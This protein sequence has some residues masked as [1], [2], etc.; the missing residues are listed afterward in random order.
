M[1]RLSRPFFGFTLV[2][3]LISPTIG[4]AAG[5]VPDWAADAV[6]YQ[7]FPERFR[8]GDPANNPTR[9]SLE[10]PINP[11]EKWRITP[12]TGDWYSRDEWETEQDRASDLE[13]TP[14][15]F[16]T[17]FDR[18]YG[19]D[20]QGV[21]EK[22]DY[23][24]DLGINTI[25]FNPVFYARSLHKYDGNSFHHIDPYFGPDPKGDLAVMD[26][27]T[28]DPKTWKW[29][30]ADKLFL[31]LMGKAHAKKIRV[32]IDGVF[33]HTGRDFFAF[34][35]L[36][37]TRQKSP[38]T[39]WYTVYSFDDPRTV[40]NEFDYKGWWGYKSLPVFAA[41]PDRND[42]HPGPKGYIFEA[43]RRWMDPDG[44]GDP[45][46]GIDGWRLDV[47]DE[48]PP[49][50]WADW[51]AHIRE[52]NPAIYT[53]AEV[54][55]DP[56]E[57]IERG[58]FSAC[59]NY[60]GF[61]IPVKGFLIDRHLKASK[62]MKLI[63]ERREALP[64]PVARAMQ[65]LIDSHDTDR[66]ASMIVN[67]EPTRYN[68]PDQIDF[69]TNNDVRSAKA[70][71]IRKPNAREREIQR[72]VAFFQ[73][74]SVGAPMIYY[75]TEAG[76]WGAHDPDCRMPM[77]WADMKFDPQAVDPRG[78]PRTPDNMNCDAALLAFYKRAIA[79]R[80]GN[81]VLSSGEFKTLG[82]FD[83]AQ[84][85]VFLRSGDKGALVAAINRSDKPQTVKV[86]LPSAVAPRLAKATARFVTGDDAGAAGVEV[87]GATMTVAL[88][89]LTGAAFGAE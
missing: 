21:I 67:G 42:M 7:I 47:A 6:W 23:L 50:F 59:M 65:N 63:D 57:L 72:L 61:A 5:S 87:A 33:N 51:H 38:Y 32:V 49:K 66:V 31:D 11:S 19:G 12:W 76:L 34:R 18:R 24:A 62:F 20:L 45:S 40:R 58:G 13:R 48:R 37:R 68:D 88:P 75:G 27:E 53:S 22:L 17:V 74:T 30:A 39:D 86:A 69:N 29:T 25:Y 83:E 14:P 10:W 16:K 82:A 15:F 2:A 43:S 36:K 84:T 70:Y 4:S 1:N 41:T 8:D 73:M 3:L 28:S 78:N 55:K 64:G 80:R 52:I 71:Q 56:I 89:G 81:P 54:W 77:V 26:T 79:F 46:D 60:H 85:V 35:D 44:N 9:G